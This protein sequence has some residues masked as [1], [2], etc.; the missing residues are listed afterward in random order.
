MAWFRKLRATLRPRGLDNALDDEL[1]FHIEQR[2]DDLVAQGMGLEEA[3]REASLLFGNR[4]V[5]GSR[6]NAARQ[7]A[8]SQ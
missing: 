7:G 1:R 4:A 6:N 3:R 5:G 8:K 2:T